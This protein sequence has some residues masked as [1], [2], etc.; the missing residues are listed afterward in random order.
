MRLAA[1]VL[2]RLACDAPTDPDAGA[3]VDAPLGGA[4]APGLDAPRT[5]ERADYQ[6]RP[7]RKRVKP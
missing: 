1:I 6:T 3:T 4:D 7:C 5:A 2:F